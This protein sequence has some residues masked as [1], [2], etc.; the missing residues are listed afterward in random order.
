MIHDLILLAFITVAL[1]LMCA[2]GAVMPWDDGGLYGA[3]PATE[4]E[5]DSD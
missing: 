4:S 2:L 5:D 1:C 3:G